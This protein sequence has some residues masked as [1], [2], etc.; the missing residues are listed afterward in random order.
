MLLSDLH[1]RQALENGQ[2]VIKPL[3]K[4]VQI[5]P[6]SIDLRLGSD[7]I[8]P[9]ERY[10]YT[11]FPVYDDAI[12]LEP[13]VRVHGQTVEWLELPDYLCGHLSTRSSLDR[14]GVVTNGGSTLVPAG[15]KGRLVLELYNYGAKDVHLPIHSRVCTIT[16][17]LLSSPASKPYHGQFQDQNS[18]DIGAL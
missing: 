1:I 14:M 12:V 11:P 17:E 13:H 8:F 7:F 2:L 10:P 18:I 3:N 9:D 5:Q 4:G 16:F 15:F 6:C